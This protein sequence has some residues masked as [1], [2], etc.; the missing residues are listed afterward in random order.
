MSSPE[1]FHLFSS[2]PTE[3]RLEIW[4]YNCHQPRV[5][6]VTYNSE[7][8]CCWTTSAPPAIL[9]ASHESRNE[10]LRFYKKLFGTKTHEARIYFHPGIDTLYLP[11]PTDMGYD[12]NSRDFAQ[13]VTGTAEVLNLAIDHVK[14]VIRRPWETYNKYV[15][16]Q[17]FP[18]VNEVSLVIGTPSESDSE[19]E[20]IR[21]GYLQM[22]EPNGDPVSIC[23]LLAD[24]KESF[25][26]EVGASFETD[27]NEEEGGLKSPPI[28]LKSIATNYLPL[29]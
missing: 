4:Q 22:A 10:G 11:R 23:R 5:V 6:E 25:S 15:L 17:S 16:M 20:G 9:S 28:V 27:H 1:S 18:Q 21:H 13:L 29:L 12:N 3:I 26:Y 14:P 19:P 7:Q 8:D 2:L 24:L